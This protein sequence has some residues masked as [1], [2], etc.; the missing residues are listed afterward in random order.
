[1]ETLWLW[2]HIKE[3]PSESFCQ[4]GTQ[5]SFNKIIGNLI[6]ENFIGIIIFPIISSMIFPACLPSYVPKKQQARHPKKTAQAG[7][8]VSSPRL[9][10]GIGLIILD[11]L[12]FEG[13]ILLN[14]NISNILT[15]NTMGTWCWM[16][17]QCWMLK[18]WEFLRRKSWGPRSI[19]CVATLIPPHWACSS[20]YSN[21][22]KDRKVNS[23]RNS[24]KLLLFPFWR[25]LWPRKTISCTGLVSPNQWDFMG[26][27]SPHENFG[28]TSKKWRFT[29]EILLAIMQIQ[30][31]SCL[32]LGSLSWR[33]CC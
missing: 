7:L 15:G 29:V 17:L 33:V 11:E 31:V 19:Y 25:L 13:L 18:T 27:Q 28:F 16:M 2:S 6:C 26:G 30:Q 1:M 12:H 8:T 24:D 14:S 22:R 3:S 4:W 21:P 5:E 20:S 32:L 23:Y 9:K 10:D